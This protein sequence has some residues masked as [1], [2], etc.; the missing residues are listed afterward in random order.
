VPS[1]SRRAGTKFALPKRVACGVRVYVLC[2]YARYASAR[3][4]R[5]AGVERITQ[6]NEIL[7]TRELIPGRRERVASRIELN[8]VSTVA[9]PVQCED[10]KVG[11][12][13]RG[14]VQ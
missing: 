13:R 3:R 10:G 6:V 1:F 5:I 14:V 4:S 9:A 8:D 2:S 7:S 12:S 11:S